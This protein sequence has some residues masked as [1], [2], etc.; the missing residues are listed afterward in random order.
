MP[1]TKLF[2]KEL[3]KDFITQSALKELRANGARVR[4]VHNVPFN[5]YKSKGQIEKGHADIQ[6]WTKQGLILYCEVK[7]LADT[8]SDEQREILSDI[9]KKGGIALV[10]VQVGTQVKIIPWKTYC[11]EKFIGFKTF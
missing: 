9:D 5:K 4:K 2:I 11:I 10:A 7:T 6:G 8:F 3:S 1:T